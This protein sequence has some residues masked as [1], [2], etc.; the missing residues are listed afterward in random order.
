MVAGHL[1]EKNGT[2]YMV[3]NYSAPDGKRKSKWISTKLPVKGNKKRAVQLLAETRRNFVPPELS[4]TSTVS[5]NMLFTDFMKLWLTIAKTTVKLTTYA[6]YAAIT[7]NIIIP[8]FEPMNKRLNEVKTI[9][10]QKLYLS[11]LERVSSS[12]VSH[13]H[14]V[15]H[16]AMKYA[17][18]SDLIV[19]SPVDK[20]DRP[21]K[22]NYIGN[23]Y[24]ADE[25]QQL[26][27]VAK[28]TKLELP[29]FFASFYGLRRSEVAGLKWNAIDF[30]QNTIT[31]KHT[32]T[33]CNIDGSLVE[34]AADTAKNKASL[35][36]LPLIPQLRD[37]L[38][39][40]WEQQE[41]YKRVCGRC[42]NKKYI[43]YICVDEM[44]NI[45][46]PNYITCSF[47]DLLEKY[48]LRKIR[49]HD[50]RH[51]C[52]SLLLRNGIPMKQIQEWLG[53]SNFS[54]TANIYAH[55]ECDSKV[56]AAQAMLVGMSG[57]LVSMENGA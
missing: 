34:V 31:I 57:A 11:Q 43:D 21:K 29:I 55:L 51:T 46:K 1:Q 6:S 9:D 22:N 56:I 19:V 20:V 45:I 26:F 15:I 40:K 7:N 23:H 30:Q 16:R 2:F 44:G 32:L 3:L 27:E 54:T 49:F 38:L 12:T 36:T 5:A 50:L 37:I 14:A 41:E 53:H 24:S 13:Y 8:Y 35:R 33:S 52:A 17:V 25:L 18:T 4:N 10:I 28:G 47:S 42:Y 48:D 39:M